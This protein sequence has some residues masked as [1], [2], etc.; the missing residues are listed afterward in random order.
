MIPHNLLQ[1]LHDLDRTSPQ[2]HRQLID[3]LR[4]D[5]YQKIVPNLQSDYLVWLVEYLDSVGLQTIFP[6][7][8]LT[9]GVGS[10]QYF[11]PCKSR[12]PGIPA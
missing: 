11:Q 8:A 5:E 7:S 4:R 1:E 10:Y 12:F 6:H 2:F 9:T 3:F